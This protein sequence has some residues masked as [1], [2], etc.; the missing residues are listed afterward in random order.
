MISC[1]KGP[2]KISSLRSEGWGGLYYIT[3]PLRGPPTPVRGPPHPSQR[4][5]RPCP[6]VPP[7]VSEGP[8]TLKKNSP[9]AGFFLFTSN[10]GGPRPC[11]LLV[12]TLSTGYI[13]LFLPSPVTKT[14]TRHWGPPIYRITPLYQPSK[15]QNVM[16]ENG[17][18]IAF[19]LGGHF[20]RTLYYS[21]SPPSKI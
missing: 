20:L 6:R 14:C 19:S 15:R 13:H 16:F 18:D 12:S 5:P 17:R 4:A 2:K 10:Q 1:Q 21:G 9:A 8:P 3:H 7:S 11:H